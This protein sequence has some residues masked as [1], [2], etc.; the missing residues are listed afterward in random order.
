MSFALAVLVVLA[1]AAM[2]AGLGLPGR[3][4]ESAR[5][6]SECVA[7]LRDPA[8]DDDAKERRMRS[9]AGRLAALA[10]WLVGGAALAI[11]L[12]L[13]AVRALDGAGIASFDGVLAML[14]RLDFLAATTVAGLLAWAL[15]R[16]IRRA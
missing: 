9:E 15:A 3:A 11:G 8:L 4:R 7:V 14:S 2:V 1:F 16:G 5:R 10:G 12:P 13:L 6:A